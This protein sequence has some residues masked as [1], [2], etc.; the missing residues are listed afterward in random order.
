MQL[1][2]GSTIQEV[3]S[4]ELKNDKIDR[5]L[6]ETVSRKTIQYS[7]GV[8]SNFKVLEFHLTAIS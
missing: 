2:P 5:Q 7:Q 8:H 3:T 1:F 4:S 6:T